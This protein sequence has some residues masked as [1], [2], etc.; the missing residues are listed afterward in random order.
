MD[1]QN[2]LIKNIEKD[3]ATLL[4]DKLEASGMTLERAS[5]IAKFVLIHLPE[6]LTDDQLKQLLPSLDDEFIEIAGVVHKYIG[7]FE[8]DEEKLLAQDVQSLIKNG[9]LDEASIKL[10]AYFKKKVTP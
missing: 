1:N 2:P 8:R 10:Q 7:K 4:L 6:N 9:K 5:T 3:I